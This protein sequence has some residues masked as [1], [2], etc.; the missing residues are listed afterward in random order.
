M[1]EYEHNSLYANRPN[2]TVGFHGCDKSVAERAK[3]TM[4][5]NERHIIFA[6]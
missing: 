3:Q 1:P 5:L 4:M 2:L 6:S